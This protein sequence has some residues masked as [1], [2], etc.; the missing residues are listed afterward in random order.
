MNWN[1]NIKEAP[2]DT[3]LQLLSGNDCFLLPQQIFIGTIVDNG[4]Y[5]AK[6]ECIAGNSEYFYRSAIV[7]WKPVET[8]IEV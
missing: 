7:A 6:G 4:T 8:R 1:Y 2:L 5:W 3:P